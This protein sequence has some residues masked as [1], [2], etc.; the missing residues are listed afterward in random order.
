MN[1]LEKTIIHLDLNIS[2]YS[3]KEITTINEK[4]NVSRERKKAQVKLDRYASKVKRI[5]E[6]LDRLRVKKI[7]T[8][9]VPTVALAGLSLA[10]VFSSPFSLIAASTIIGGT[11]GYRFA[12]DIVK[13]KML[14][15]KDNLFLERVFPSIE[16][17][18]IELENV[19]LKMENY[20]SQTDRLTEEEKRLTE[21]SIELKSGLEKLKETRESMID[22]HFKKLRREYLPYYTDLEEILNRTIVEPKKFYASVCSEL[23]NEER[24]DIVLNI[25]DKSCEN[26]QNHT[27]RKT[28]EEKDNMTECQ[29]WYNEEK[30][31]MSKVLRR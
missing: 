26:C 6:E 9:T 1:D 22:L 14:N 23:T 29:A 20:K 11:C 4:E 3:N 27:C 12:S 30:I 8:L 24:K 28:Q 18:T 10:A 31:G 5:N 19:T 7:S 15:E 2:D 21:E 17:K 13:Y 16:G 25:Q